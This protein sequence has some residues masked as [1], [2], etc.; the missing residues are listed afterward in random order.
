VGK[1][2]SATRYVLDSGMRPIS[3]IR[4][5]A[6]ADLIEVTYLMADGDPVAVAGHSRPSPGVDLGIDQVTI[7][8]LVSDHS[9]ILS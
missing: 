9:D 4:L 5:S 8:P 6:P 2:S 3:F 7:A 1:S